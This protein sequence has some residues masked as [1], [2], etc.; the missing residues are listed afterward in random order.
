MLYEV[1]T[2]F[3]RANNLIAVQPD[4]AISIFKSLINSSEH[5]NDTLVLQS[6]IQVLRTQSLNQNFADA[7]EY[8]SQA[9]RIAEHIRDTFSIAEVMG[10]I[11]LFYKHFGKEKESQDYLINSLALYKTMHKNDRYKNNHLSRAYFNL[12]MHYSYNFV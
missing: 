4:S 3:N 8:A 11:G 1:I 6:C 10:D 12:A 7:F 2:E 5:E 9:L